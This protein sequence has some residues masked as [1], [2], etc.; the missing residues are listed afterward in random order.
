[1]KTDVWLFDWGNTLMVDFPHESGKMCDWKRVEIV[2]GAD[3]LLETLYGRAEI[4]IA[5]DARDSSEADIWKALARVGLDRYITTCFCRENIGLPKGEPLYL[6]RILERLGKP[7]E[8]VTM[9]G[10]QYEKDILP[11]V[12][13]GMRGILLNSDGKRVPEDSRIS[14]VSSLTD[15]RTD[16]DK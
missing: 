1:M 15:L 10:D 8:A 4:C 3:A 14:V 5:T 2:D 12:T 6:K 13:I 16:Y 11:A 7:P 9:V